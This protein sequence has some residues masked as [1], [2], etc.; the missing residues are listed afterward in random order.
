MRLSTKC[1]YGT[2]AMIDIAR[3]YKKGPVNRKRILRNQ[4]IS[5]AYLENILISLKAQNLIRTVRGANG[6]FTLESH[7]SRITMFQIVNALEGSLVPTECLEND[8]SCK[9]VHVCGARKLWLELY[10]SQVAILKRTTLQSLVEIEDSE[11]SLDY[12]I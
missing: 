4:N 3:H 8:D 1:T 10:N 5:S 7:P 6:G 2:R 11:D 12:C 9:R